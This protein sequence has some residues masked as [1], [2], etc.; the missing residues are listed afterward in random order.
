MANFS[1]EKMS[2]E[3]ERSITQAELTAGYNHLH[4]ADTLR[5]LEEGRVWF[6]EEIGFP[7]Q[8]LLEQG[9]FL[10]ITQISVQY[11]RELFAEP[12]RISCFE[13]RVEGTRLSLRQEIVKAPKRRAIVAEIEFCC[14][15]SE[16]KR[17][18]APPKELLEA[19][20]KGL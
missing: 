7:L 13:P 12:V 6:L 19:F 20:L 15:D 16:S 1:Y 9:L 18:I 5:L 4:H 10:V 2:F 3:L 11:R 14:M 8:G 17:A